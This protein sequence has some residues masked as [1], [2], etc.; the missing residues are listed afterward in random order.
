MAVEE[1]C[2]LAGLSGLLERGEQRVE[3]V[4]LPCQGMGKGEV[5]RARQ[6]EIAAGFVKRIQTI[7]RAKRGVSFT[8]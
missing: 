3:W 5:E 8:N 1:P 2:S 6:A 7:W 4:Y